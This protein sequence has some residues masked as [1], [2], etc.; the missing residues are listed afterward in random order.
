MRSLREDRLRLTP[1]QPHHGSR[2][3]LAGSAQNGRRVHA[4]APRSPNTKG[5]YVLHYPLHYATGQVKHQRQPRV[6]GSI[7][8]T[9]A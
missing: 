3:L 1:S 4:L 2:R 6:H 8:F 7:L 9:Q 5:S